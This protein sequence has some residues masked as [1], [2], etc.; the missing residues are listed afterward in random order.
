[1][2][3]SKR[4]YYDDAYTTR[5]DAQ[6]VERLIVNDHPAVV[7]DQTY[8][9]PESGGQPADRGAINSVEVVDVIS[10]EDDHAVLHVLAG[11]VQ[12]DQAACQVDWDRR[13][14]HMQHHTG[15]H[16]LTQ[17]F[18]EVADAMTVSFHLSPNSVTIDLDKGD[19]PPELVA[20]VEDRANQIVTENRPV[21]IQLVDPDQADD[22]RMRK[23][24]EHLTTDGLRVVEVEDYDRTACG[25]THVAHAGEIGL[26][27][28][29]GIINY[30]GGSRVEFRCGARALHDYQAKH[31]MITQVAA[32]LT[33]P[34]QELDQAIDRLKAELKSTKQAL[35]RATKQLMAYEAV[36][37]LHNAVE[38]GGVKV[39]RA[40]F[41][42]RDAGDVRALA[43]RLIQEPDTVALLG[44]AGDKA[45]VMCARSENLPYD[46]NPV[47]KRALSVLGSDR[48]GGRPDFVQ[49][50]GFSATLKQIEAA[51][52]EAEEAVF[53]G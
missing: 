5:F 48:G 32:D 29:V 21:L 38:R 7:L 27:K 8:F 1:M 49:G 6:I 40:A 2:S 13:F 42:D 15:Q 24:L 52:I 3:N 4:L 36:E 39:I 26:I 20:A 31:T 37:M 46:M 45:Q 50:G 23:K 16:I 44:L 11:E 30:K 47:L 53:A 9:Y 33:V 10:R 51:L 17:A 12:G 28:V 25:G 22:V 34:Y 18:V 19:L 35:T 43:S 41:D 14:D